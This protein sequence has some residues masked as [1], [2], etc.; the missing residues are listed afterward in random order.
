MDNGENM[1]TMVS[2]K[3][4][5]VM[6]ENCQIECVLKLCQEKN[7]LFIKAHTE[8]TLSHYNQQFANV[9]PAFLIRGRN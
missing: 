7:G 3:L 5:S 8:M 2:M 9:F 4:N 6:V 1:I